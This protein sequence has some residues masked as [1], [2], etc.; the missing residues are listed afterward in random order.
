MAELDVMPRLDK[1]HQSVLRATEN[2]ARAVGLERSRGAIGPGRRADL[3]ALDR[4]LR[5]RRTWVAGEEPLR[6]LA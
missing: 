5:V 1:A 3:V 6:G 2:P 4:S